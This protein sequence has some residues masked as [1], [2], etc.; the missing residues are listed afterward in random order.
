MAYTLW[1]RPWLNC[2]HKVKVLQKIVWSCPWTFK[3]LLQRSETC[4]YSSIMGA[5]TCG[6]SN[7][8]ETFCVILQ[9]PEWYLLLLPPLPIWSYVH[10]Y[11]ISDWETF[12]LCKLQI[13][14]QLA[15]CCLAYGIHPVITCGTSNRC[16]TFCVILQLAELCLLLLP[17]LPIW[18]YH[19][20]CHDLWFLGGS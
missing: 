20:I 9:F 2:T 5:V 10:I 17:P 11:Y 6:T 12:S 3:K 15:E 4:G 16:E 18:S 19:H 7:Q 8:C 13:I 1:Y 14:P